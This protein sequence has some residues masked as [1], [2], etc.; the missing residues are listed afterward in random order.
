MANRFLAFFLL[1]ATASTAS[2]APLDPES[3]T[4][5]RWHV[6]V[7]F[8]PHRSWN[9]HFPRTDHASDSRQSATR[10]ASHAAA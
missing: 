2:A 5:Y 3:T 4:E 7:R 8:E 6:V 1:A 9:A 10:W